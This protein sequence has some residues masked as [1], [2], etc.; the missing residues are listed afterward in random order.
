MRKVFTFYTVIENNHKI[1]L[2]ITN[3]DIKILDV[4]T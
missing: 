2:L 4:R 3:K 1:A